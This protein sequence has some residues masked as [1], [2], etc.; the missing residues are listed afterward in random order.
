[1]D[2]FGALEGQKEGNRKD[3]EDPVGTGRVFQTTGTAIAR[4]MRPTS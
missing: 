2:Q 1:M 4:V 3:A